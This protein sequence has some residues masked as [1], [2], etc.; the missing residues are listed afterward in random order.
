MQHNI[1]EFKNKTFLWK[2]LTSLYN[3]QQQHNSNVIIKFR[4]CDIQFYF[5]EICE[6]IAYYKKITELHFDQSIPRDGYKL[7]KESL[8]KNEGIERFI[9]ENQKIRNLD[10]LYL[11]WMLNENTSITD[12]SIKNC[13]IETDGRKHIINAIKI[14]SCL[15]K[16]DFSRSSNLFC[17]HLDLY[18]NYTLLEYLPHQ[19]VINSCVIDRNKKI[20][21][22]IN[23]LNDVIDSALS[24]NLYNGKS[25]LRNLEDIQ[26]AFKKIPGNYKNDSYD[27]YPIVVLRFITEFKLCIE[28]SSRE[29][30]D[31]YD[32]THTDVLN[33]A[34]KGQTLLAK[35][36]DSPNEC[37]QENTSDLLT[38]F[39]NPERAPQEVLFLI[40][41]QI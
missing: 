15:R 24:G 35:I 9:I 40:L 30:R 12:L 11:S 36:N 21:A 6:Y 1:L 25:I 4:R 38:P 34:N 33:L 8:G 28:N 5:K 7:L 2:D 41:D 22:Y 27:T 20:L 31:I 23:E 13:D 14:N 26:R 17:D 3:V 29:F 16:L 39:F 10:A 19:E 32:F 18:D 37:V